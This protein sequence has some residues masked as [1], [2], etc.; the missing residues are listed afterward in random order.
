MTCPVSARCP[1]RL[2]LD[3]DPELTSLYLDAEDA[4]GY[5][6]DRCIFS[7]DISIEDTMQVQVGY[8]NGVSM[9]YTLCAY[10]PWEGYEIVFYGTDGE[11]NHRHVG[12]H[13]IF[14]GARHEAETARR[15]PC[16]TATARSPEQ[17]EVWSG[18][19]DHGGGDPVMLD[20]LFN[21]APSDDRTGAERA[22]SM[23]PGRS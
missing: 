20:Q 18:E 1:Y 19:G 6:R 13:G 8:A 11:L 7:S 17:V 16:S 12:V 23:A 10:S 3:G 9:N 22:T 5:V 15:R 21:P 4:D 2:D 14:G